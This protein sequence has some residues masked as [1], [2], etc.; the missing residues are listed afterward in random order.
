MPEKHGLVAFRKAILDLTTPVIQRHS[1]LPRT[2]SQRVGRLSLPEGDRPKVDV[3]VYFMEIS[4]SLD[5]L[6]EIATLLTLD[7]PRSPKVSRESYLRLL[8]EFY[9]QEL[10]V[11]EQRLSSF[12]KWAEKRL[13][14]KKHISASRAS[15]LAKATKLVF[16]NKS[17]I[18]SKHVHKLRFDTE[19][20]E[21]LSMFELVA[22]HAQDDETKARFTMNA[23]SAYILARQ[24]AVTDVRRELAQI[25]KFVNT[26]FSSAY[27]II[28]DDLL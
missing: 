18:R 13:R 11:L 9:I 8:M 22:A 21:N 17:G 10:Y 7:P 24:N 3:F 5:R 4:D 19:E 20:L 27:G 12:A 6:R 14:R 2:K 15:T 23:D 28:V 26:Y 16:A 25:L 1:K